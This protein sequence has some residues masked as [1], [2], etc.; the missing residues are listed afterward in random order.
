MMRK[1]NSNMMKS[2]AVGIMAGAALGAAGAY[3]ATQ[4]PKQLKKT[5][6]KVAVGA[7]KAIMNVEKMMH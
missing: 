6:H 5:M 7:E 1:D 2:A 3:V 4:N